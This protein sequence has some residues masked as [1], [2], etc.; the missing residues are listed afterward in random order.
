MSD[1]G[2]E[3][4]GALDLDLAEQALDLAG[5]DQAR[6]E[7][8]GRLRAAGDAVDQ[9]VL[10]AQ[11]VVAGGDEAGEERVARA[12][13]RAR[14]DRAASARAPGRGR[15]ARPARAAASA[16]SSRPARS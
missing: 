16:R 7:V 3:R 11:A 15:L 9:A 5:V 8:L 4:P 10:G 1:L 6:A 13:G 12:D 2:R 14:L